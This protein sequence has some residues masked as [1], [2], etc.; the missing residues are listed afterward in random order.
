MKRQKQ[1]KRHLTVLVACGL[2][3]VGTGCNAWQ[4]AAAAA[5]ASF[6]AG[7][8]MGAITTPTTTETQ[9]FRNGVQIDCSEMQQLS[10]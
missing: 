3:A 6:G 8:L 2:L 5:S 10:E 4:L 9:C 7:W 1:M